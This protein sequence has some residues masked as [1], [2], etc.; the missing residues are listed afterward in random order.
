VNNS[1]YKRF[2]RTDE[3]DGH[4]QTDIAAARHTAPARHAQRRLVV[5]LIYSCML[6]YR[7]GSKSGTLMSYYQSYSYVR[8]RPDVEHNDIDEFYIN[9]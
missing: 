3:C 9:F 2:V 5:K 7:D 1:R 4:R 8:R 6:Q